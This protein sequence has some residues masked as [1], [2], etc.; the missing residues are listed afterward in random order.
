VIGS[1]P[2]NGKFSFSSSVCGEQ[3]NPPLRTQMLFQAG[4]CGWLA[5]DH[6]AISAA[7]IGA[8]EPNGSR[9]G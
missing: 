8:R 2:V 6:R 4:D 9:G 3:P 1:V 5:V 7:T